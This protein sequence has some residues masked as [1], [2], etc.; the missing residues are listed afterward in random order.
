MPFEDNEDKINL[1]EIQDKE[2]VIRVTDSKVFPNINKYM[3]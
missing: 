3:M 1:S 2:A